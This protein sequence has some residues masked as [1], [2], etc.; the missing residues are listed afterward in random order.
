[1]ESARSFLRTTACALEATPFC[2]APSPHD[3]VDW[4]TGEYQGKFRIDER[5]S[6]HSRASQIGRDA[7][8]TLD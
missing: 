4:T 5:D 1:M 3:D 8:V 6:T 2:I 7:V